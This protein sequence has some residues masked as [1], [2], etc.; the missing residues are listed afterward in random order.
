MK[1][2]AK[3]ECSRRA[4]RAQRPDPPGKRRARR[5][6]RA[7]HDTPN[8]WAPKTTWCL[9]AVRRPKAGTESCDAAKVLS[10]AAQGALDTFVGEAV[11]AFVAGIAC[12]ALDP[13][14][15]NLVAARRDECIQPL[16]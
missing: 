13:A 8:P 7:L 16:P 15:F 6:T 2:A 12:M 4:L 9:Q 3:L 14:P 5:F 10:E 1:P 11:R